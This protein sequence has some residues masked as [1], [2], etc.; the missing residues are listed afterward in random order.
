MSAEDLPT[1]ASLQSMVES[2]TRALAATS[3]LQSRTVGMPV[4]PR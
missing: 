4:Q 3:E 2:L 1:M